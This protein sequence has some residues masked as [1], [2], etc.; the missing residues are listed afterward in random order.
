[1]KLVAVTKYD[2]DLIIKLRS[3]EK[4][5]NIELSFMDKIM[6]MTQKTELKKVES[7]ELT[8]LVYYLKDNE[9]NNLC[10]L[11]GNSDNRLI[12]LEI[13][14]LNKNHTKTNINFVEAATNYAFSVLNAETVTI[15]SNEFCNDNLISIGYEPLGYYK[16]KNTYVKDREMQSEIGAIRK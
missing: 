1:M 4:K 9:I 3:F 7:V 12:E 2:E 11:K 6:E 13:V 16:G 10:Y 8:D 5:A 14:N 15:L